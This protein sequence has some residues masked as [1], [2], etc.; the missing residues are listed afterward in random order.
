M[1]SPLIGV[2]DILEEEIGK[3]VISSPSATL[4]GILKKLG[5]PDFVHHY[6]MALRR[7]RLPHQMK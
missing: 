7:P 1:A 6:G 2:A 5:I 3:P 4:Y